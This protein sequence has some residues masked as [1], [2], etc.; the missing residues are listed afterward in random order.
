M[1]YTVAA[2]VYSYGIVLY[3]IM[4]RKTP[5]EG[6]NP[7]TITV[8][9]VRNGDRPNLSTIPSTCNETLKNLAVRC[10]D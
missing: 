4:A 7:M 2:D 5:Y 10:W 8:R 9:V 1:P 3:E 6:Q